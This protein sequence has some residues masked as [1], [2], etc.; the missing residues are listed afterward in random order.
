M[1]T[2]Q[3]RLGR[4]EREAQ[5]ATLRQAEESGERWRELAE[6]QERG[7]LQRLQQAARE[8]KQKKALQEQN[9][10]ALEEERGA[11][12]EQER[13]LLDERLTMAELKRQETEHR[14]QEDRRG[15]NRA[16]KRRH[17]ALIR[18]ISRREL[19]EREEAQR[20]AQGKL[21]RSL[22]NYGQ[23]VER[24]GQELREKVVVETKLH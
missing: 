12:L 3:R 7:R 13:L 6:Q 14:A 9:L 4:Q 24:R 19:E 8:E 2:R 22:E 23:I 21:S 16:E 10:R 20:A 11:V 15:L 5:A 18:E 1:S 17:A